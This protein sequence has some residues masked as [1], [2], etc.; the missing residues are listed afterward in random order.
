M[1]H[2]ECSSSCVSPSEFDFVTW[3][4][5]GKMSSHP[6]HLHKPFSYIAATGLG[7]ETLGTRGPLT[8]A[9]DVP[10][11]PLEGESYFWSAIID[12]ATTIHVIPAVIQSYIWKEHIVP[13]ISGV[14]QPRG[15]CEFGCIIKQQE[16]LIRIC[17]L[18]HH[19]N[20]CS[21]PVSEFFT[22][23][24]RKQILQ[25]ILSYTDAKT[26]WMEDT[27]LNKLVGFV[28]TLSSPEAPPIISW[29]L[30]NSFLTNYFVCQANCCLNC[31]FFHNFINQAQLQC[32]S[33][34]NVSS[35]DKK[36]K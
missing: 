13:K 1:L 35:C 17:S 32:F 15:A 2:K 36:E 14:Q 23:D 28:L 7:T 8:C 3:K 10:A 24:N 29:H 34:W 4:V 30:Y 18:N 27:N 21:S 6:S 22:S 9:E 11:A 26:Q 5:G 31:V 12:G 20:F 25:L 16:D 33:C 19:L